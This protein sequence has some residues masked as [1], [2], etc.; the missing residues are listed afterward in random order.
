VDADD[1]VEYFTFIRMMFR[2]K[3]NIRVIVGAPKR[4]YRNLHLINS[5]LMSAVAATS[6]GVLSVSDDTHIAKKYWDIDVLSLV[7]ARQGQ[8]YLAHPI[9]NHVAA[10][11]NTPSFSEFLST[12]WRLG[13]RGFHPFLSIKLISRLRE[14]TLGEPGW[15]IFGNSIMSD[16][17]FDILAFVMSREHGREI[18]VR[19]EELGRLF[20]QSVSEHKEGGLWGDSPA[21]R[22]GLAKLYSEKSIATIRRLAASLST[23]IPAVTTA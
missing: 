13:P 6:G 3:L 15:G 20:D 23:D 11:F 14:L 16:S 2:Q 7:V 12:L 10:P 22:D 8:V 5:D 9:P 19:M 18:I 17:F 1:D 4:G 21:I